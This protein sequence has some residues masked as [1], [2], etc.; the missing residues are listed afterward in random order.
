M[1]ALFNFHNFTTNNAA[2]WT[3]VR[4][5]NWL[6]DLLREMVEDGLLSVYWDWNT[7]KKYTQFF[8]IT[9]KGKRLASATEDRIKWLNDNM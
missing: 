7:R 9:H 2:D 5:S 6:R 3:E 1:Q 8:Q 4:A